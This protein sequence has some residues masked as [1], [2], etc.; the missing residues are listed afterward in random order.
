MEDK[1]DA[2]NISVQN[3]MDNDHFGGWN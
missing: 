1:E 3:L 2:Y